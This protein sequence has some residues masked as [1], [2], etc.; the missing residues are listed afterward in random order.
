[1]RPV[2]QRAPSPPPPATVADYFAAERASPVRHEFRGGRIVARAGAS[3]AHML[4][5]GN[6][7]G[8]LW[9]QLK[10]SPYQIYGPTLRVRSQPPGDY[11]YPDAT[12]V[13]SPADVERIDIDLESVIDPRLI[14]EVLSTST[15][16]DDRGEK[17]DGYRAIPTFEQY[18]LAAQDQPYVLTFTRQA[19]G[20]WLMLP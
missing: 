12:V 18:V 8:H 15:E 10:G 5:N 6:I 19:G 9:G 13:R 17:F 3:E 4:V 7:A 11:V 2:A 20:G 14:V 1:M 16:A